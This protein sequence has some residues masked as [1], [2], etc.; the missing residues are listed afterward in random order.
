VC[1]IDVYLNKIIEGDC[2]EVLQHFPPKSID[3]ILCDLPYGTTHNRWDTTIDL[4]KLWVLYRGIIKNNGAIVLTAQGAFTALLILSNLEW[5]RYKMVWIKSKATNFLNVKKQPLR[6][7]EDICVFYKK[8]PT[9]NLQMGDGKPYDR[10]IRTGNTDSYRGFKPAH[11]KSFGGRYPLDVL[12]YDDEQIDDA[13][14]FKSPQQE[15]HYHATQKPIELGRYLVRK[16]T[17]PGEI[18]LDNACGSGS[19]L[20]SAILE[21][22]QFIGIEKNEYLLHHKENDKDYIRICNERTTKALKQMKSFPNSLFP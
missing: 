9:Y 14:Y 6:K 11:I 8:Q 12:F 10:G 22:R 5:F 17:K 20:V 16:Y 18:V 15:G 1:T 19:F 13:V 4:D 2:L 3:M 21:G 7:H